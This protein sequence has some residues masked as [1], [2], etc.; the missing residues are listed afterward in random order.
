LHELRAVLVFS[1][2]RTPSMVMVL[3]TDLHMS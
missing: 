1:S 3:S 2:K